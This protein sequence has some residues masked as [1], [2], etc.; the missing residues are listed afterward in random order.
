MTVT[1][2]LNV[3]LQLVN[4]DKIAEDGFDFPQYSSNVYIQVA[5]VSCML[6]GKFLI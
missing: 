3:Y 6:L 4:V 5:R 1:A 2:W